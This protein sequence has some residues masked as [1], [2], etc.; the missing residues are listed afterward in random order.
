M[1]IVFALLQTF[2][3]VKMLQMALLS[4]H[5][6]DGCLIMPTLWGVDSILHQGRR[7]EVCTVNLFYYIIS[8]DLI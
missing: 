3:I 8:F 7:L 4:P 5:A 6:F 1:N 2:F